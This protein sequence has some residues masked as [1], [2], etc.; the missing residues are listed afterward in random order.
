VPQGTLSDRRKAG[1]VADV[2]TVVLDATGR[3]EPQ[4][5][6]RSGVRATSSG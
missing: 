4:P 1:L 3:A 2:T 5:S 6:G